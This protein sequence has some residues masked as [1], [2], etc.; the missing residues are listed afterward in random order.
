[1]SSRS[2]RRCPH[3]HAWHVDKWLVIA[4]D[5]ELPISVLLITGTRP[6]YERAQSVVYV[7]IVNCPET[8]AHEINWRFVNFEISSNKFEQ[9]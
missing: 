5:V 8:K 1:L 4:F 6:Q 3:G 2:N 7:D 9:L